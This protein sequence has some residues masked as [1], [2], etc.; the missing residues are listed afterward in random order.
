[1][2]VQIIP[3]GWKGHNWVG[4]TSSQL[5]L[6]HEDVQPVFPPWNPLALVHKEECF[7]WCQRCDSGFSSVTSGDTVYKEIEHCSQLSFS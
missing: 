7:A 4:L 6:S 1:M 3:G 5:Q 2:T